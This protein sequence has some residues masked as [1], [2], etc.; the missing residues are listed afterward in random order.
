MRFET[1]AKKLLEPKRR[2]LN[3]IIVVAEGHQAGRS[4]KIA[5]QLKQLTELQYRVCILGH[6]QT[7]WQPYQHG[8]NDRVTNGFSC[9]EIF[10][11][12]RHE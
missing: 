5:A 8:S 12:R 7:R 2:K 3:S 1:V 4:W 9:R 10:I 11:R 6:T